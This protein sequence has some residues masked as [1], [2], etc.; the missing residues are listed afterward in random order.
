MHCDDGGEKFGGVGSETG[1][2]ELKPGRVTLCHQVQRL[3]LASE[4]LEANTTDE[5]NQEDCGK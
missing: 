1:E 2:D 3:C 5:R 4:L